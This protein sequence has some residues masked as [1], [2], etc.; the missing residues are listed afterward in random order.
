[1]DCRNNT[2]N[3]KRF[4]FGSLPYL[5]VILFMIPRL[6]SAQFGLLD[7]GLAIRT[8]MEMAQG[9][10]GCWTMARSLPYCPAGMAC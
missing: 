1:M 3:L 8:T 7:D 5:L 4:F 2:N 10:P 9:S 6:R